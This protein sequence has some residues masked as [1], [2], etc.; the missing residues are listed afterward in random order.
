MHEILTRY[1]GVIYAVQLK[2]HVTDT[3]TDT[4]SDTDFLADFRTRILARM[5]ACP[6]SGSRPDAR[7]DCKIG[8]VVWAE[9]ILI[10]IALRVHVVVRRISP[11][12]SGFTGPIF[13]FF[14]PHQ[15]ALRA[16]D[17]SRPIF[18]ISQGTLPWQPILCKNGKLHIRRSSIQKQNGITTC[19]CMIK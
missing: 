1:R 10:K 12:I 6:A 2:F 16:D 3:D 5:S 18:P 14:S 13:T 7:A 17:R 15:S 11:N 4:D 9:N 19:I 8:P